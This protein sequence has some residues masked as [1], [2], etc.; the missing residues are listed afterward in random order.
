MDDKQEYPCNLIRDLIPSY[1][2]GTLSYHTREAIE[3]HLENCEECKAYYESQRKGFDIREHK[4]VLVDKMRKRNTIYSV[5]AVV[6]VIL[7]LLF[8]VWY[9]IGSDEERRIWDPDYSDPSLSEHIY[10]DENHESFTY[11]GEKYVALEDESFTIATI[12]NEDGPAFTLKDGKGVFNISNRVS[13]WRKVFYHDEHAHSVKKQKTHLGDF[14]YIPDEDNDYSVEVFATGDTIRKA[15]RYYSKYSNYSWK[16]LPEQDSDELL[17]GYDL[18][19]TREEGNIIFGLQDTVKIKEL[20]DD[21]PESE[22]CLVSKDGFN[23]Y[24][25]TITRYRGEWYE[26]GYPTYNE[27]DYINDVETNRNDCYKLPE[28]VSHKIDALSDK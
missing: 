4:A 26:V 1:I 15:K 11:K 5:T 9:K 12:K 24:Y 18:D 10:Y 22:L 13:W 25:F 14:Y 19:L 2:A 27:E 16:Y 28:S 3:S 8:A 6:A 17:D 7:C 21:L 23:A 20:A